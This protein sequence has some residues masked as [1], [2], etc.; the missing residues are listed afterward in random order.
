MTIIISVTIGLI[1]SF[2]G[3]IQKSIYFDKFFKSS[4]LRIM[5]LILITY[6]SNKNGVISIALTI[7]YITGYNYINNMKNVDDITFTNP[8]QFEKSTKTKQKIVTNLEP[9]PVNKSE[10]KTNT[11]LDNTDLENNKLEEFNNKL[12]DGNTIGS[13][14][15]KSLELCKSPNNHLPSCNKFITKYNKINEITHDIINDYQIL[16]K[17]NIKNKK[18]DFELEKMDGK[19][20]NKTIEDVIIDNVIEKYK[21]I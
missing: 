13:I 6:I 4:I 3:N 12:L 10:K 21:N 20:N 18:N 15:N 17:K 7:F 1:I 11:D 9:K 2:R 5:L 8:F 19:N 14:I 16:L